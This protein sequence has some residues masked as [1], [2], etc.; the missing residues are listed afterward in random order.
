[1]RENRKWSV[2]VVRDT[3]VNGERDKLTGMKVTRQ[4]P[5]VLVEIG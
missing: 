2:G 3:A 1:M 5:F 4:F